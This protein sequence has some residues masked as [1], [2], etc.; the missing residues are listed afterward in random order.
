MAYRD[1]NV[2]A[3]TMD[4]SA[5]RLA[6]FQMFAKH[7]GNLQKIL[8][9]LD[10]SRSTLYRSF[11]DANFHEIL[12]R[13]GWKKHRGAMRGRKLIPAMARSAVLQFLKKGGPLS[14]DRLGDL[15]NAV[16]GRDAPEVRDRVY[17]ILDRLLEEG[18][19]TFDEKK[20]VWKPL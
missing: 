2:S 8:K 1:L 3:A 9:E 5:L 7:D 15:A 10:M 19:V 16:W 18:E 13:C 12:E 14:L 4:E 11:A 17:E 6:L 20:G